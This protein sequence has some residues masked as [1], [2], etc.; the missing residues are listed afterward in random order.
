MR[1]D[2]SIAAENMGNLGIVARL[3]A[4][5]REFDHRELG[6]AIPA[7]RVF[8]GETSTGVEDR[9]SDASESPLESA[10]ITARHENRANSRDAH[11]PAVV[12]AGEHEIEAAPG[13]AI[14]GVWSVR[15]EDFETGVIRRDFVDKVRPP[16]PARTGDHDLGIAGLDES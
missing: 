14:D 13:G 15:Q 11:L 2:T 10:A 4:V 3:W 6:R 16:W 7:Q 8:R 5:I 1:T 9:A 12:M